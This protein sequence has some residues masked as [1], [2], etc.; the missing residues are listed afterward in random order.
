MLSSLNSVASIQYSDPSYCI[1]GNLHKLAQYM[2]FINWF[3][4]LNNLHLH[5]LQHHLIYLLWY[6]YFVPCL[7]GSTSPAVFYW[8]GP[9]C[10]W[11]NSGP[12]HCWLLTGWPRWPATPGWPGN[13]NIILNISQHWK[14][15]VNSRT[16]ECSVFL[17]CTWCHDIAR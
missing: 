3:C 4:I 13:Y 16:V 7:L 5:L 6:I 1:N 11:C 17:Q 14:T 12:K 10:Y 15:S 8:S 2:Y 9:P